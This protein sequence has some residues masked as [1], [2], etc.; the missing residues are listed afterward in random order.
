MI[1]ERIELLRQKM[2]ACGI[3]IYLI[4]T[5]DYHQSEYV[6]E[7][8]KVREYMTGFTGSAGTTVITADEA[9]LWTD[10]RYYVQ[11]EAELAGSGITLYRSGMTGVPTV[12]Q[13]V[14]KHLK[15]DG[16]IGFDGRMI[17]ADSAEYYVNLAKEKYASVQA[18]MDLVDD[19]WQDRPQLPAEP[20]F[21]LD[22][23]YTGKSVAEKL[24]DIRDKMYETG[25]DTHILAS[26]Y[27]IAWVLNL[28]GGDIAHV[29][30]FLSFLSIEKETAY[31]YANELIFDDRIRTYLIENGVEI[32]P[33]EAVYDYAASL[34]GRVLADKQSVN[35]RLAKCICAHATLIN[36]TN[37]SLL[38]K[39]I[40]NETEQINTRIAHLKDGVAVTKFMYW[41]KTNIGKEEI[42]ELSAA[43]YLEEMRCEQEHYLGTSFATIS[44]YGANGAMMH[45]SATEESYAVLK[46]EGFY[47]VDSG[48]HYLEGTT[49]VT[50]TFA[51]GKLS[52]EEKRNFTDV[53]RGNLNLANAHF[54]YG[55][56]GVNLDILARGPLWQRHMDYRCGTGH[57]VGHILN[58]HEGP[59]HIRWKMAENAKQYPLEA[60]MITTDEPGLYLEG[61]YGIRIENELL[62]L[63][64]E[65]NEYGQYMRFE[66]LTYVPIDLDAIEP[67]YMTMQERTWLNQYHA[68]VYEKIA[69]FLKDEERVW[70]RHYTRAI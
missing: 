25:A 64:D 30:V 41:L 70:L 3:D 8:F 58:V 20:V 22:E 21:Y 67:D 19:I 69:P 39:A 60:G 7:Y 10:G 16:C 47:L 48:G 38:M 13:Y 49:D 23:Q 50:R 34:K 4:P 1:Q 68:M 31:L 54:L 45:Y 44:A 65:E 66:N 32:C 57:G 56:T 37:P 2:K 43:G 61:Q 35:Y 51:L 14:E 36:Q 59:N 62:C 15:K 33:Y 52:E 26:L 53:C 17:D 63:K 12:R 9:G 40:K 27:D 42:T 46:P 55:C 5:A 24:A 18:E 28:R 29:P 6:G 11:A